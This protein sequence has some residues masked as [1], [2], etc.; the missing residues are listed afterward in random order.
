MSL[1]QTEDNNVFLNGDLKDEACVLYPNYLSGKGLS[2]STFYVWAQADPTSLVPS[3][4]KWWHSISTTFAWNIVALV[5]YIGDT[6]HMATTIECHPFHVP[7][8][9]LTTHLPWITRIDLLWLSRLQYHL[10]LPTYYDVVVMEQLYPDTTY[11]VHSLSCPTTSNHY[12]PSM[13]HT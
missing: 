12:S 9:A 7:Q 1:F 5:V 8:L 11:R 6:T 4:F 13:N 2:A 10:L 3:K